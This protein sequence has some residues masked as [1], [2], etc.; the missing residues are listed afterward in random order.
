MT[1]KL[2]TSDEACI[3]L[4]DKE[5]I[6]TVLA[7]YARGVDRR[8]WNLVRAAYHPDAIDNHGPFQGGVDELLQWLERR[9]NEIEQSMHCLH[10]SLI[11]FFGSDLAVAETYCVAYQRYGANARET[12]R[13]WAGDIEVGPKTKVMVEMGCRYV[14]RM[15]RRKSEWRIAHRTVVFEEIKSSV[16]EATRLSNEWSLSKRDEGDTLWRELAKA[17][18]GGGH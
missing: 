1:E 2:S 18:E 5:Q 12:I 11:D 3:R 8:D 4:V 7:G 14:D 16:S 15:E 10:N 13:L 9:H 6:R 17:G